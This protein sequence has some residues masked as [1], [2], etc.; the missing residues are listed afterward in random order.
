M[1]RRATLYRW[2]ALPLDRITE[3]VTR[4]V[5]SGADAT[6]T[7]VYFKKGAV[8]PL[9]VHASDLFIYVLQGALRAHIEGDEVIV[10]EG[11]VLV[12]S[13]GSAHQAESL[14]DTFVITFGEAAGRTRDEAPGPRVSG[15]SRGPGQG[16]ETPD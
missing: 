2:D 6:L 16:R 13:G 3:M 4:K 8:V 5:V 9:H 1:T 15:A 7:Q 12:V 11:E 14:D 10:R